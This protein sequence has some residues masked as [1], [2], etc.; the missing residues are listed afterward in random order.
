MY[1]ETAE[2][3]GQREADAVVPLDPLLQAL[4]GRHRVL[5]GDHLEP[6]VRDVGE[7]DEAVDPR[8]ARGE[9]AALPGRHGDRVARVLALAARRQDDQRVGRR[10]VVELDQRRAARSAAEQGAH[11]LAGEQRVESALARH[12][13]PR[14]RHREPDGPRSRVPLEREGVNDA[15]RR[16]GGGGQG[17]RGSEDGERS[18]H[19]GS[20]S[21]ARRWRRLC[22]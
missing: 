7:R 14:P 11:D 8:R 18:R 21:D 12:G 9:N 1:D 10:A 22:A 17:K 20:L 5:H 6:A 13:R 16:G 4:Q 15:H 3:Q 19:G 2:Q